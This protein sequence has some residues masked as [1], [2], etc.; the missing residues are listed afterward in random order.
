MHSETSE[1]IAQAKQ[2]RVI[3]LGSYPAPNR[4]ARANL[5]TIHERLQARGHDSVVM[6]MAPYNQ[7]KEQDA[8]YPRSTLDLARRILRT[9]AGVVHLHIGSALT[10]PKL[11]L[12]AIINKLPGSK[13][14]CTLHLGG[15]FYP[16][17][18][19]RGWRGGATGIVLRQFD[20]LIAINPEIAS[21]FGRMGVPAKRIHLITPFPRLGLPESVSPSQEI[22]AF[23]RQHTPLI[24][25]VGDFEPGSD[26]PKQ[27]DILSKVR[28]RYPSAGLIA[29]GT[30]TL[31]LKFNH[32]RT[33][34][35]DCN[36]IELTGALPEAVAGELI[37]RANVLLHTGENHS[38]PFAL[39]EAFKANMPV[40]NTSQ[41]PRNMTAA[42]DVET[43]SLQ[44]LRSLQ[45]ARP[46]YEDAPAIFSDGVDDVIRLYK[47]LASRPE[48]LAP[49]NAAYEWPSIG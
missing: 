42:G 2:L 47:Q 35:Q 11:A 8:Y 9:R 30:G 21:F 44:V 27:F 41:G 26:L 18:G 39:Q 37:R 15:R 4:G 38:D 7:V 36:H 40:V 14:I 23:C 34:H 16:K 49:L 29:I 17:K 43:A 25:S 31:H 19:L 45:I 13:K 46:Q 12:A 48:E 1:P 32:E 22:E 3:Q 6:Q 20:S 10:L 28:E 33:L 5:Q 24:A